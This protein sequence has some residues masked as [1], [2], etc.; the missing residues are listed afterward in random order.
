MI[1]NDFR[2]MLGLLTHELRTPLGAIVGYQEL[3]AEGLLGS[4]PDRALD[5]I[6]RIGTSGAQMRHL[7]DGIS[8]LMVGDGDET[9][10]LQQVL[11]SDAAT[12]AAESARALAAGRGVTLHVSMPDSLPDLLTDGG[13]MAAVLDLAIGAGIRASPGAT[14]RL[15]FHGDDGALVARLDGTLL[16]PARDRPGGADWSPATGAGL[17]LLMAARIVERLGGELRVDGGTPAAVGVRI[18]SRPIDAR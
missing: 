17:R 5:A 1:D 15:G 3:L 14:L 12:R 16:D 18:P 13:R 9:L 2:H 10:D 6:R 7:I 11:G 4:I 8:E